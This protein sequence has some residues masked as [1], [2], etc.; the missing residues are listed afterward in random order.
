MIISKFDKI[1]PTS[2]VYPFTWHHTYIVWRYIYTLK[3]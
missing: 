3:N 2:S 1:N